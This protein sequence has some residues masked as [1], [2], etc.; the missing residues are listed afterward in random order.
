M[1]ASWAS[2]LKDT[3]SN[4]LES[5]TFFHCY[6]YHFEGSW[7]EF[8]KHRII[9]NTEAKANCIPTRHL[10]FRGFEPGAFSQEVYCTQN[11]TNIKGK[12]LKFLMR[13]EPATFRVHVDNATTELPASIKMK[14][15]YCSTHNICYRNTDPA[16]LHNLRR[17]PFPQKINDDCLPCFLYKSFYGTSGMV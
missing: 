5:F 15:D 14:Q 2:T 4:L 10:L 6:F 1:V 11:G 3:G 9:I 7:F 8:S 17:L 16:L 13:F 12:F